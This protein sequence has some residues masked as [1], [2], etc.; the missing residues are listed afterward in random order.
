MFL[1]E[2]PNPK[3]VQVLGQF[4][5]DYQKLSNFLDIKKN[6][7]VILNPKKRL[8]VDEKRT[9]VDDGNGTNSN[10]DVISELQQTQQEFKQSTL[11]VE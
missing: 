10:L 9:S 11:Q 3:S 1:I 5:F 6:R 2:L 7:L 8:P 4:D